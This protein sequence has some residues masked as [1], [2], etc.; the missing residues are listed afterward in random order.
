MIKHKKLSQVYYE[1]QNTDE[2]SR[3]SLHC[4]PDLKYIIFQR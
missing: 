1:A 4:K 2:Q 3:E